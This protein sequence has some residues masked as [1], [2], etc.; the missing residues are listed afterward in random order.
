MAKKYDVPYEI[1]LKYPIQWGKDLRDTIIVKRR[2]KTK[3]LM[4]IPA[5][6][7]TLGDFIKLIRNVSAEPMAFIEEL[8]TEDIF[9]AIEVVKSFLPN[10]RIIGED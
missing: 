2:L 7:V 3:D 5:E 4:S 9:A 8:D 6:D 10:S 1:K